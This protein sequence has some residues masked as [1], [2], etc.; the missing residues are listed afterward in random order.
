MV[1]KNEELS[2]I[3]K[4]QDWQTFLC[5]AK[6]VLSFSTILIIVRVFYFSWRS[7]KGDRI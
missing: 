3:I 4:F 1:E 5:L 6:F 2:M 7:I